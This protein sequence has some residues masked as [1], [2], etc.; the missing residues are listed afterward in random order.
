MALSD[1]VRLSTS[2]LAEVEERSVGAENLE[3]AVL[4]RNRP[5]RK[6]RRL[7]EQELAEILGS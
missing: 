4:D 6:F 7:T 3:A 5:R 1:A 2:A